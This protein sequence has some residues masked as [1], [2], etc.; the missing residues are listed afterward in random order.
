MLAAAL[1]YL[2][3]ADVASASMDAAAQA[4]V[5]KALERAEAMHTA[6]RA[7]TLLAFAAQTG[8]QADGQYSPRAWL[9]HFTRVTGGAAAGAV[10][11]AKRLRDHPAVAAALAGGTISASWA[12]EICCWSEKL[13]DGN[14]EDA[15]AILLAA[16][17][18]GADLADLAALAEEMHQ[19]SRAG[20]PD[21]DD[22]GFADRSL[23]LGKTFGGAGRLDGDL[24]P[25]A[26]AALSAVLDALG[27]KAGPE[28]TRSKA[29][30]DHDAL[31]E[32]CVR[33]I[34]AT[35]HF[36]YDG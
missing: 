15:D 8:P 6:A 35:M 26:T 13:P 11:W 34:A 1:G 16:A 3:E 23:R 20:Q 33:L 10:G 5:L 7:R 12:R 32:A 19:R 29:Q 21:T 18:G 28:D 17:A 9:R 2:A 25:G 36:S 30:R 22:D 27:G 24:T 14:R 4:D 31:E